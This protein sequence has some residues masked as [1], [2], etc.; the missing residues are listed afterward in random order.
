MKFFL[1]FFFLVAFFWSFGARVKRNKAV[2]KLVSIRSDLL[3][4]LHTP[5]A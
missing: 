3:L 1:R 5:L 2:L 4:L